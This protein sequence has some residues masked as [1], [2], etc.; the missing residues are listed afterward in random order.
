MNDAP[1]VDPREILL[2]DLCL[3]V[4]TSGALDRDRHKT[5][6][7]VARLT[8]PEVLRIPNIGHVSL[9]EIEGILS[10]HGLSLRPHGP[11]REAPSYPPSV[12][13]SLAAI[14][15]RLRKI[16]NLLVYGKVHG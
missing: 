9:Q 7:D 3:S 5:L 14:E 2:A 6:G 8:A 4:R 12:A 10:R 1:I 11:Y 13:S 16:E 15:D